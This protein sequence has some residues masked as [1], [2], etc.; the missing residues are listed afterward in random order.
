MGNRRGE[1]RWR[2][3]GGGQR[4]QRQKWVKENGLKKRTGGNENW[5]WKRWFERFKQLQETYSNLHETGFMGIQQIYHPAHQWCINF[6]FSFS[7]GQNSLF[8]PNGQK[9]KLSSLFSFH[10]IQKFYSYDVTVLFFYL[11]I[12]SLSSGTLP[13]SGNQRLTLIAMT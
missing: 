13:L 3:T 9:L 10:S 2:K 11:F 6:F 1:K 8:P 7:L 12:I 5:S 4:G